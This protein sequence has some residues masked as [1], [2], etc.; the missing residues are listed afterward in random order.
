MAADDTVD[1]LLFDLGGV[2]IDIDFD[3]VFARWAV[4]AQR[5]PAT[6]K[7]RFVPDLPYQQHERGEIDAAAYFASLRSSLDIDISN[8]QFLDGWNE[9]FVGEI[10]GMAAV[11]R[12]ARAK[13]PLYVFTNS[14]PTHQR[15]WSQRF[16]STLGLFRQVFVSSDLGKRKPEP[17]AFHA[18][19]AAMGVPAPRIL[20]FDDSLENVQGARAI[21]LRAVHVRSMADVEDGLQTLRTEDE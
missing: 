18:V 8:A 20:F 19:A 7:E 2:V 1:A 14:N 10:P 9:V 4:H 21:G 16:S 17:E 13:V 12:R 15:V 5:D 11:L 6:I 3:R